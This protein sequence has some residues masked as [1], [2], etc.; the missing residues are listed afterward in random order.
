MDAGS[1]LATLAIPG[2]G[3]HGVLVLVFTA[4]VLVL[5]V[6][7]RLP[8][9]SV[10]LG[11]LVGLPLL[12]LAFPLQ[13]PR[14]PLKPATFFEGF[15]HP[16]LVAICSLMVLGH[17]LVVTGA[18]EPLARRLSGLLT[19]RPGMTLLLVLAGAMATSGFI[20]DTPVVVLLIP[21]LIAA[22]RRAKAPPAMALMPMNYAVLIGG[23]ATTIGTSTNL[24]VATMSSDLGGPRLT[25]FSF[26]P[27]VAMAAVPALLYLWLVAP[28]LLRSVPARDDD[29]AQDVFDAELQIEPQDW[30]EG[31]QL[32][33]AMEATEGRMRIVAVRDAKGRDRTRLPTM[34]LHAGDRLLLQDTIENLKEFETLL[35]ARLHGLRPEQEEDVKAVVESEAEDAEATSAGTPAAKAVIAQLV[36]TPQSPLTGRTVRQHR[37][38]EH[39]HLAAVGLRPARTASAWLRED[40][41]DR[42]L[43]P[44]D[45][46][47]VQGAGTA[48][49][50]A[51]R[52]GL[53]LLLDARYVLPR[54]DKAWLALLT[55]ACVVV[56]AGTKLLPIEVAALAGVLLLLMTRGL[57]WSDV[58]AALS[59]K[60][61][62]LVASSLALG[63]ALSVTGATA[64]LA[65]QLVALSG[66]L[67]PH[68]VLA[69][70]MGL[71]GLLTN[72]VSNNAAAAI[73]TP[74]GIEMARALGVPPEPYVLAV[75]FG[76]NLCYLTPMGYQ[77]NLLVMNAAGYRF[78]DFV[79][80]GTPLFLLMWGI[81]TAL[82]SWRYGL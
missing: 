49:Q 40:L 17:A 43:E 41:F 63:Q 13:T 76:C 60:V 11:I 36:V 25:L 32:R 72:F 23:M 62:L 61:I 38:V 66:G 1:W 18:L 21:L 5:F 28:R 80:V 50:D 14:G 57:T 19:Q 73:G 6:W 10:C 48:V 56:L 69:L 65:Q 22:L 8:I 78:G 74:L 75:L 54:Q 67:A 29:Y 26:Y 52:D 16:A 70:L 55:M 64:Y 68:W 12:F 3:A 77:T 58:G 4:V 42:R 15:G 51:Q 20:N 82:L 2:L 31:R 9:A 79:R 37:L 46:L 34:R 59:A 71:M 39:Y 27:I 33:E 35:K 44:G 45:V 53:G 30:L 81:L 47:L 24:I 7:D